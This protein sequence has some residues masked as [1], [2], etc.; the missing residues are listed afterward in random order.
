[1]DA[2]DWG[3]AEAHLYLQEILRRAI[4]LLEALLARIWHCL[5]DC[6]YFL[7]DV[8]S[9]GLLCSSRMAAVFLSPYAGDCVMP[10]V[11]RLV[12]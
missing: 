11:N 6:G 2:E 5:H 10:V 8:V 9:Q 1:M 4:D 3:E 7:A 12:V